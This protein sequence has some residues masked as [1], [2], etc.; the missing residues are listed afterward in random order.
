MTPPEQLIGGIHM[1]L[2]ECKEM[3]IDLSEL[4]ANRDMMLQDLVEEVVRNRRERFFENIVSLE[5][6]ESSNDS[7]FDAIAFKAAMKD[8]SIPFKR[9]PGARNYEGAIEYQVV[10]G[11]DWVWKLRTSIEWKSTLPFAFGSLRF[12]TELLDRSKEVKEGEIN[13]MTGT[14]ML[15]KMVSNTL[16][17]IS[18]K[19]TLARDGV[20]I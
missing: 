4:G 2:N 7:C 14:F 11:N 20:R 5:T 19:E 17:E 18:A 13:A 9:Q 3:R 8:F 1:K 10:A 15:I 12:H 16:R 6:G